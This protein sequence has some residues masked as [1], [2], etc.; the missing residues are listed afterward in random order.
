MSKF[1]LLDSHFRWSQR[2]CRRLQW[3]LTLAYILSM[4]SWPVHI[5][6]LVRLQWKLTLAY[7]LSTVVT[8]L[9]LAGLSLALLWYINFQS[10]WL[11]GLIAESLSKGVVVLRP[12]LE[13]TPPDQTALNNWLQRVT[14]GDFLIIH[15]PNDETPDEYDTVPAQLGRVILVAIADVQG[16]VLAVTP[17]TASAPETALPLL[18][19]SRRETTISSA[20][21]I[22]PGMPLRPQLTANSAEIF[23]TAL[24]G[25]TKPELLS[26]RDA[27]GNLVASVPIMSAT[28]QLVGVIYVKL[29]FPIDQSEYLQTA[30]KSLVLPVTLGMVISGAMAG[31][32]F[33]Y[34]IARSLTHRLRALTHAA[35]DWSQGNFA[36]LTHDTSGDELGQLARHLNHMAVELQNMLQTRQ[37]LATMEERNRLARELHDSVKQQVFATAMQ[38]GA[39]RALLDQNPQ[40]SKENLAEAEQLVRQAQQELTTLIRELRPA[41]LKG[42][43]LAAALRECVSD[44]SRQSHI[45]TEVRIRGERS[46]PLPLEQ[47]LYRVAQEALTNITRH[48]AASLVEVELVWREDQISLCIAD[49]GRGFAISSRDGKGLGLQSMR[50]RVEALGGELEVHSKPGAGTRIIARLKTG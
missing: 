31:I 40:A 10:N 17:D 38:V 29:A 46:L 14:Q 21:L 48:S 6:S 3:K 50:E 32:L 24:G 11:P 1:S 41:A 42:K 22:V 4:V 43:G 18:R 30:L 36:T 26:G 44:W 12:H 9:I 2:I 20:H 16:N 34:L 28:G 15:I 39:A 33:G 47:A 7:T 35:D 8:A 27:Q 45:P 37:E 49:N 5:T 19:P 25:E 13:Q 23:Q